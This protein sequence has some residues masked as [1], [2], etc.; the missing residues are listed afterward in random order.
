MTLSIPLRPHQSTSAQPQSLPYGRPRPPAPASGRDGSGRISAESS[1]SGEVREARKELEELEQRY[2]RELE[3]TRRVNELEYIRAQQEMSRDA[4]Q[5][6]E[7]T[8]DVMSRI[9]LDRDYVKE[10]RYY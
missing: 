4:L 6:M 3:D 1:G 7:R 9:R 5:S 10:V 2:E 8:M